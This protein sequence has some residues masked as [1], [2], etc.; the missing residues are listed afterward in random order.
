MIKLV[1]NTVSVLL[2]LLIPIVVAST[3]I[4]TAGP[5]FDSIN[6]TVAAPSEIAA[7]GS[8]EA[9]VPVAFNSGKGAIAGGMVN[10][11]S[12]GSTVDVSNGLLAT[13]AGTPE[14]L[15]R[16]PVF[17]PTTLLLLSTGLIGLA[18]VSR[19]KIEK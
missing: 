16:A 9:L 14:F 2:F 5:S 6:L 4:A 17:K 8:V 1:R 19:R 3:P 7:D 18:G 11:A 10:A 15:L 12:Q 13:N